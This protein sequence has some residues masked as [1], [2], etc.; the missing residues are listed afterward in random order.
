MMSFGPERRAASFI[1]TPQQIKDIPEIVARYGLNDPFYQQ[2]FR[3]LGQVFSGNFG[4]SKYGA[5]PVWDAFFQYIP[6]TIE[7]NLFAIPLI[8]FLGIRLGVWA[9]VNKDRAVDHITRLL[10]VT[11][12]SLPTFL[13]GLLL[14]MILYGFWGL[15]PPGIL[16]DELLMSLAKEGDRFVQYTGMYSIDGL[17]NGRLDVTADAL[18][19]LVLPV[20]TQVTVIIAILVR[21]TR[22]SMIEEMSKE[23]ILTARAK[24]ADKRTVCLVHAKKNAM[25]PVI[26]VAGWLVALS[27]Q[28]SVTVEIIFNR[29]GVGQ[30]V[31]MSAIQMDMPPVMGVCLFFTLIYVTAN[32]IIDILYAVVDPRIRLS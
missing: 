4:W 17:L 30:W 2:Y 1:S 29:A 31:A 11:G 32:L 19:H 15:F 20:T 7:L 10:A 16:S 28:G 12:W 25:I 23:F 13:F 22:S 14:M 21:V 27:L 8:L 18:R 9:G 26:T 5:M 6:I 3:W 24:G